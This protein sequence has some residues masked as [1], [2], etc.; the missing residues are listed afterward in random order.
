MARKRDDLPHDLPDRVIRDAL[1]QGENLRALIRAN[2]PDLA[3]QMDYSRVEVV[4]RPYFLDDWRQRENDLLLRLPFRDSDREILVCILLEHQSTVDQ[5]MPLRLLLYAV[6]FW[7]QEWKQYEEH[8]ERGVPLRL[9]PVLPV[10][11][12]TGAESWDSSRTLAD[13]FD[14]PEAWRAWLPA[15]RMPLWDLSTHSAEELMA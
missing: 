7:E 1:L 12:Y 5:A 11:L 13:L 6:F 2:A 14:V 4:Q 15:W 3:D 8:H 10:V 9:T